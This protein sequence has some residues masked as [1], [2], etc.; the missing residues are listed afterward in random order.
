MYF[1]AD[2]CDS[3]QLKQAVQAGK[4]RFGKIDG[5]I[6][7]AGI[8]GKGSI[9]KKSVEDYLQCLGPKV[10]GT[11]ALEEALQGEKLDF[12]CYFSSSSAILGDFGNGDYA[13]GN[14]F[15]MSYGTYRNKA[16]YTGKTVV[17]NWPLWKSE[18]MG[19]ADEEG[20]KMYLKS[21]GQRFL[22]SEE[23]T[24]IFESLLQ[25]TNIQHLVMTGNKERIYKFLGLEENTE[26]VTEIEKKEVMIPRGKGR[27][28]EMKDWSIEQCL[29]WELKDSISQIL[30]ISKEKLGVEEN[31]ADFGF[32]SVSLGEF[33]RA[34]SNCFEINI[35]PDLF[36]SYPTIERLTDYLLEHYTHEMK[37]LYQEDEEVSF[38]KAEAAVTI[39]KEIK[40]KGRK[41]RSDDFN[42]T[43]SYVRKEEP[44]A[45]I[46][47][48]GR[49][50]EAR[51]VEELWSIL[52]EGREVIQEA[53]RNRTE[54]IEGDGKGG[55]FGVMPGTAEFDPLFFGIAPREANH[56]DPRQR[57]LLQESWNA[58]EDAGYGSKSFENEKVGMF[59][60]IE[61]GDY[62]FITKDS[63]D[64]GV[65]SNNNAVL[66]ARLSYILNLDGP[67]MAINTACSSGLVA[68]HQACQSLRNG[69][70]DTAIVAGVNLMIT[71]YSYNSMNKAGMLSEN[72]KCYAFDKRANGMV[73]GEAI[74]VVVLKRLSKAEADRNPIYATIKGSGIN[75][76]GKTNGITAPSGSSQSRLIRE[77]YERFT[78]NPQDMEY[79]VTHGTG[80]KLGD[81]IEINALAEA[82]KDFTEE[83]SYCA[84]T[85][86]KPNIGHTLAASGIVSLISLVMSLK[87]ETIPASINCEQLN[88]Y[89]H[90]ENSPFYVNRAN[91]EWKDRDGQKR[92]SAVSSFGMSGTNAHVVV[93][94]YDS[95][96]KERE[97]QT[98]P[99]YYLLA[100]SAKTSEALQQKIHDI[101]VMFER[102]PDMRRSELANISYTLMEGR[103]HFPHRC[104]VVVRNAEEAIRTFREV[105]YSGSGQNWFKGIM[106]KD[107]T[108]QAAILR[109][110]ED[111]IEECKELEGDS[112]IY[113]ENLYALAEYYCL[114]Y[115]VA[116]N[117]LL[118][119]VDISKVSLPT[120]PFAQ[121][122]YWIT[123]TEKTHLTTLRGGKIH[124]LLHQNTS[125]ISSQRFSSWFNGR[126]HFMKAGENEGESIL[127]HVAHIEMARLASKLYLNNELT[128]LLLKDINWNEPVTIN[129]KSNQINIALYEQDSETIEWQIYSEKDESEEG[130][131]VG[132]QG[133]TMIK[134]ITIPQCLNLAVLHEQYPNSLYTSQMEGI[135]R[136]IEFSSLVEGL[137]TKDNISSGERKELLIKFRHTPSIINKDFQESMVFDPYIL[138][139]CFKAVH[140]FSENRLCDINVLSLKE[141]EFIAGAGNTTWGIIYIHHMKNTEINVLEMDISFYDEY[142]Q[143]VSLIRGL[144]GTTKDSNKSPLY[145]QQL[146]VQ[147]D[148]N[149]DKKFTQVD[150][151]KKDKGKGNEII[152]TQGKGRQPLMKGWTV[153]QC[154]LWELKNIVSQTLEIPEE[155]LDSKENLADFGFD[156]ISLAEFASNIS[157]RY[158]L[159]ITP[160]V[161]YGYPTIDRLGKFLLNEYVKDM[162][163][164]Y[165]VNEE[166]R[167]EPQKAPNLVHKISEHSSRKI[168]RKRAGNNF[169]SSKTQEPLAIIGVSGRFPQAESV[170]E[171]W[172]ILYEGKETIREIPLDR[173]EWSET[174][175]I[176]ND[177]AIRKRAGV[178]SGV[179]EFDPLFFE[180]SPRDAETMDPRQRLLLEETWKALEDAGYGS[181]SFEN[182]KVGM[183]VGIEDGDYKR[184]IDNEASITS[185]H[186]AI[187]A[188]RLSYFLNLDGPNMAINTACSSGLV[189]IHQACQSLRNGE[190]DTAI[191]AGAN[192]MITSESYN[193]MYKAGML[194]EDGRCYAFDKRANGMVPGEAIAVVVLK[195]ISKAEADRNPIYATIVGSGINYD[196]KTNGITAPSRSSQSKL[197]KEVYDRF[198][199]NPQ[200]MEYIVTHGTGTKLGDPVEINALA[201]AFKDFT[202]E[203]SYCALTS[204]KPNIGHTLA[205][206]GIVS[207]ISL[208]MSLKHDTIPA[209]INCE[210]PNDYIHWENS[211]FYVNR[212]NREWKDRDGKKR[213]GAVSSFGMSGTNAHVVVQSYVPEEKEKEHQIHPPYYLLTL[214]A[215]TPESLQQKIRDIKVMFERKK[216]MRPSEMANISYTLMEGRQHFRHRCAVVVSDIED[217]IHIFRQAESNRSVPNLF[218]GTVSRD[219][220]AQPAISQSIGELMEKSHRVEGR[221]NEYQEILYALAEYYCFGYELSCE[222]LLKN[223]IFEKV[224]LPTYPFAK[225]KYWI[226]TEM[227]QSLV[228]V[229]QYGIIHPLV[230]ENT[231]NLNGQR[232]SSIFTGTEDFIH[233]VN[234]NN[235]YLSE[236]AH[237]EMIRV[238]AKRSMTVKKDTTLVLQN[239]EWIEPIL[240][241]KNTMV[242]IAL[243]P[244]TN[245]DLEWEIYAQ[246]EASEEEPEVNSEGKLSRK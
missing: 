210:Q 112:K 152:P 40:R 169:V 69:E 75:Y 2:V 8:E 202:E 65:T 127:L 188:A 42:R 178:L 150:T 71:P 50:P 20:S 38:E 23:G 58:L 73:P 145:S 148:E 203:S 43:T 234:E 57:L 226:P 67:N 229:S 110:V 76:D 212:A 186:N 230:H 181:K 211:P 96:G 121:E 66:A 132:S 61:D 79:I 12:V 175:K 213:L 62:R 17:I 4:E 171:L 133:K 236:L 84:L 46:G 49:F 118:S 87:H 179:N 166:V 10:Q 183:F 117:E 172:S 92:L 124:P 88:D 246:N 149:N 162:E 200:E 95:V 182:D 22:E 217:A 160:D 32:D 207:L 135:D 173:S 185:N 63:S 242:N 205:A 192:L 193:G 191:V 89:I 33:S 243:Y 45:I 146:N 41:I 235:H 60:G 93:E 140:I 16:D 163:I 126:E 131:I 223:N 123:D 245:G 107:F 94:S 128:S 48:S 161:F 214:S 176:D 201:E 35:T 174:N 97:H 241:D 119:N 232:F 125:D 15:L 109:T 237:L 209:S 180:I 77:I 51:S 189:A 159:N 101:K 222:I 3:K 116:C 9:L 37:Q 104:A 136:T 138:D 68:I 170:D 47:I 151:I 240:V 30:K 198:N 139:T 129:E 54:W 7:A 228:S 56:M 144:K 216:E 34:L 81:P 154:V 177:G 113:K 215:K 225:E 18:G 44:I 82:F 137:W 218:K 239:V 70:C 36:F 196:G 103:Q 221:L 80:T 72:G 187:L 195:R 190:C 224:N 74:G 64:S 141:A 244:S 156:S 31:L 206:S 238:A 208:V 100:L 98:H 52:V 53:P 164:F 111:L 78:I 165:H 86:V 153:E 11:L 27:R 197:I 194:S 130:Y 155:K 13:V 55:K 21:S 14:R 29:L 157:N 219:F 204:V 91:K 168:R 28:L 26:L 25:Q 147:L 59:V 120:Y 114:G 231:S 108:I 105:G 24:K 199:I 227:K 90:W 167:S 220:V 5:V 158:N 99:P 19:F 85:S 134:E 6:H 1:S 233:S 184:L 102:K 106:S 115:E 143:V 122:E 39:G 142:G 83:S